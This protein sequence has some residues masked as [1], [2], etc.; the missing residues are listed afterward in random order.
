MKFLQLL[1]LSLVSCLYV[2]LASAQFYEVFDSQTPYPYIQLQPEK[3]V[4]LGQMMRNIGLSPDWTNRNWIKYIHE[5]NP[6]QVDKIG[7]IQYHDTPI[8]VPLTSL[9]ILRG[10]KKLEPKL[11]VLEQPQPVAQPTPP[12][13]PAVMETKVVKMEPQ[14]PPAEPMSSDE[15]T[16]RF[17]VVAGLG[18]MTLNADDG[19]SDRAELFSEVDGLLRMDFAGFFSGNHRFDLSLLIQFLTFKAPA[20]VFLGSDEDVL[21][22][23]GY[24]YGYKVGANTYFSLVGRNQQFNGTAFVNSTIRLTNYLS[25]SLGLGIETPLYMSS[26]NQLSLYFDALA[27]LADNAIASFGTGFLSSLELKFEPVNDQSGFLFG[28]RVNYY[29]HQP[30]SYNS[31]NFVEFLALIGYGF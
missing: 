29:D 26:E 27:I 10:F 8:K 11:R 3:G 23:F 19:V 9:S 24:S 5:N 18:G 13:P 15:F 20:S 25:H 12:A 16:Y 1:C 6:Q 14:S 2:N 7:D 17:D 31:H 4:F 21:L 30:D 22:G 28:G